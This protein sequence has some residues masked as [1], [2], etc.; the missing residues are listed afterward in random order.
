[1]VDT[2][3]GRCVCAYVSV[4]VAQVCATL[5]PACISPVF[6]FLV[7][8]VVDQRLPRRCSNR[9]KVMVTVFQLWNYVEANGISDM[10]SHITELAVDGTTQT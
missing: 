2:G 9:D 5:T 8:R 4:R 10:D 1:M 7:E 3:T 6:L